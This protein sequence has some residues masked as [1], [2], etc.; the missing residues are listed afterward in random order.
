MML[1]ISLKHI[2]TLD[3]HSDYKPIHFK[4][5]INILDKNQN[6]ANKIKPTNNDVSE[7]IRMAPE[8]PKRIDTADAIIKMSPPVSPVAII[9]SAPEP[10]FKFNNPHALKMQAMHNMMIPLISIP[11][12]FFSLLSRFTKERKYTRQNCCLL[13][14]RKKESVGSRAVGSQ[15]KMVLKV[16]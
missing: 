8:R 13:C 4:S 7:P 15:T 9:G 3:Y 11:S 5:G 2:M 6:A 1:K 16:Q 12:P 14:F 10:L